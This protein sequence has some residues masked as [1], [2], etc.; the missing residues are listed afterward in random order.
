MVLLGKAMTMGIKRCT[1][2]YRRYPKALAITIDTDNK[3]KMTKIEA[4]SLVDLVA[5]NL[6]Q[7]QSQA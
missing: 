3:N 4:F 2:A 1:M 7:L 5:H 6:T